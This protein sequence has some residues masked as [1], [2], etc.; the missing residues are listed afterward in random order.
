MRPLQADRAHPVARRVPGRAAGG[1]RGGQAG[2]AVAGYVDPV[3]E[4]VGMEAVDHDLQPLGAKFG[5]RLQEEVGRAVQRL[6]GQWPPGAVHAAVLAQHAGV[7]EQVPGLAARAAVAAVLEQIAGLPGTAVAIELRAQLDLDRLAGAGLGRATG[8]GVDDA[9]GCSHALGGRGAADH[10][11]ALHDHR[12]GEVALAAAE[13]QRVGLRNAVQQQQGV[14]T[15]Q[16]LAEVAQFLPR[17]RIA[18]HLLGQQRARVLADEGVAVDVGARDHADR[19]RDA[20]QRLAAAGGRDQHGFEL[21]GC[22][23]F[24]RVLG[25]G[26]RCE[27]GAGQRERGGAVGKGGASRSGKQ[28]CFRS[29]QG[30]EWQRVR[31]SPPSLHCE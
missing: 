29:G 25:L 8:D 12:V 3:I 16:A 22:G 20:V 31:K 4:A 13:A 7:E 19:A 21:L 30:H 14:A 6:G 9:A 5:A 18:R 11:D 15:A 28:P 23:R 26:G 2:G 17:W 10:L 27:Q 24:S 1:G